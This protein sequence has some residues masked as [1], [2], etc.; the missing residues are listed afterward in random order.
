MQC[1]LSR[2]S[3]QRYKILCHHRPQQPEW[4]SDEPTLYSFF[5]PSHLPFQTL[6][7][8]SASAVYL[9]LPTTVC[10]GSFVP[11]LLMLYFFPS[12]SSIAFLLQMGQIDL[13]E[14]LYCSCGT[15]K[16][17]D[18]IRSVFCKLCGHFKLWASDADFFWG[19][20]GLGWRSKDATC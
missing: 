14:K 7:S 8:S 20:Q 15:R 17:S 5:L 3:V 13:R 2:H 16:C 11:V 12:T 1:T 6:D 9:F 19:G 18:R 10:A 4:K